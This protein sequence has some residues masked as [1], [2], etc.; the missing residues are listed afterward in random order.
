MANIQTNLSELMEALMDYSE[1]KKHLI[2][3]LLSVNNGVFRRRYNLEMLPHRRIEDMALIY[4]LDLGTATIV[5]TNGMLRRYGIDEEQLHK[6]AMAVTAKNRPAILNRVT[7]CK[8]PIWEA[9]VLVDDGWGGDRQTGASVIC[10][11]GFLDQAAKEIGNDVGGRAMDLYILPRSI[12]EI[13]ILPDGGT[14]TREFLDW[15][16]ELIHDSNQSDVTPA[17]WLSDFVYHYDRK[18]GRLEK[19]TD[20][21][22]RTNCL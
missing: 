12:H 2:I 22:A 9:S 21:V 5:V 3:Q 19:A 4:H 8:T 7:S 20:F 13:A 17:D 10:Y 1:M 14:M 15:L 16:C 6:D 11:P 18:E